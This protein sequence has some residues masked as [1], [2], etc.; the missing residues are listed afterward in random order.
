MHVLIDQ[1]QK[2]KGNQ[3]QNDRFD[4]FF[5]R[6]QMDRQRAFTRR[7]LLISKMRLAQTHASKTSLG[8]RERISVSPTRNPSNP[9]DLNS[10]ISSLETIPLSATINDPDGLLFTSRRDTSRETSKVLRSRLL[11]PIKRA[12][13]SVA[14]FSSSSVCTSTSVSRPRSSSANVL[15][16]RNCS[17]VRAV[18]INKTASAPASAASK[19]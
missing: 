1:R 2:L 16:P 18:T 13:I 3:S 14:I 17:L 15:K 6:D 12:P 9:R 19:I 8:S 5:K 10:I 4:R 7:L 11:T